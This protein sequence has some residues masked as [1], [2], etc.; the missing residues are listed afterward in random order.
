[1]ACGRAHLDDA[2]AEPVTAHVEG[3]PDCRQRAAAL[4]SDSFLGRLRAAQARPESFRPAVSST[5]GL[6]L[7]DG[8][9]TPAAPPPASTLPPGLADL[10]DYEIL[11]ELG[12][13]GMGVVFLAQNPLM[14]RVGGLKGGRGHPGNR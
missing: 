6:S 13:G 2:G 7:L 3:C 11:R 12:Q 1:P 4:T 10:P 14:G 9:A 8:G 5:D